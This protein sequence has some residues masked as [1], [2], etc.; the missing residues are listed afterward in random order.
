MNITLRRKASSGNFYKIS[1]AIC[2]R[3]SFTDCIHSSR[4]IASKIRDSTK[5]NS[6]KTKEVVYGGICEMSDEERSKL[7][8]ILLCS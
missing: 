5:E 4:P 7:H 6:G 8:V 2:N 3:D 1:I